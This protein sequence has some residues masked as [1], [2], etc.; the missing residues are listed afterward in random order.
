MSETQTDLESMLADPVPAQK[1][2]ARAEPEHQPEPQ[3][4]T[5]GDPDL[6]EVP[7]TS[8]EPPEDN[9]P[10]VPRKA[11]EDYR[12]KWQQ[13]EKEKQDYAKQ[14]ADYQQRMVA[15]QPEAQ[16]QFQPPDPF[17]DPEGYSA[18]R[19]ALHEEQL[20]RTRV[21]VSTEVMKEKHADYDEV[22]DV[23]VSAAKAEPVLWQRLRQHPFPA[24]FAY[25]QGKRMKFI[26]EVGDDP[27]SYEQKIIEKF[28]ASQGQAPA[29]QQV[30]PR[31]TAPL[32]KSLASAPSAVARDPKG[33]YAPQSGP[34]TLSQLLGEG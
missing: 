29:G 26:A 3:A 14:L 12:R 1:V 22:V 11:M 7:P 18:Y 32:P 23:F 9:S 15:R 16:Q 25:E 31:P 28:L 34:P 17:V 4:Q 5:T 20:Y 19:D 21:D 30:A 24:R 8:Q 27:T 33:R 13:S 10:T 6:K 2:E